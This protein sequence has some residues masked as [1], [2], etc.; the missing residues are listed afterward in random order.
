MRTVV[1]AWN[2]GNGNGL[3]PQSWYAPK[4]RLLHSNGRIPQGVA[5]PVRIPTNSDGLAPMPNSGR[6]STED[7]SYAAADE[8]EAFGGLGLTETGR[9]ACRGG[10][11]PGSRRTARRR[12]S[13][14][15][16]GSRG[17]P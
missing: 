13:T 5:K 17:P 6:D 12:R 9:P 15:P 3:R 14:R 2:V 11:F 8:A 7:L 4:R 16:R 10:P 1:V